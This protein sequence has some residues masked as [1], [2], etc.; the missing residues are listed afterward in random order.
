MKPISNW[1][2]IQDND[3][4]QPLLSGY[5]VGI[6]NVENDEDK[7]CMKITY[8]IAEGDFRGYY[9]ERFKKFNR[10]L[11]A[12]YR[13]YKE[14]ALSFFKGFITSVE[15]SNKGYVWNWDES[16][17]KNKKLGVILQEE[18]YVPSTGRYAGEIRTRLI[19]G[20]VV[21][22]DTI[23]SKN[24]KIP[25]KKIVQSVKDLQSNQ[26]VDLSKVNTFSI[27]DDDMPF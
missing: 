24:Y 16:T 17:L 7:E 4:K 23:Y 8:D 15:K 26:S 13:S 14:S 27:T 20:K 19:V 6:L 22:I 5:V 9:T 10:P 3:Y 12:F 1:E 25:S 11:P 21:D 2:N 18:D